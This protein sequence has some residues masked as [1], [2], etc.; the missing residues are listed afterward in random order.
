MVY[1]GAS[2]EAAS[3]MVEAAQV[4]GENIMASP[5]GFREETRINLGES[6]ESKADN[7]EAKCEKAL[8][9]NKYCIEARESAPYYMD[10]EMPSMVSLTE[11]PMHGVTMD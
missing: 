9:I 2:D 5:I 11:L 4:R 10:L 7:Y 6:L 3:A 1:L 8:N